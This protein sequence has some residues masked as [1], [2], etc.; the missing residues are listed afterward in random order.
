MGAGRTMGTFARPVPHVNRRG[1]ALSP[2]GVD[3]A[4]LSPGRAR[5]TDGSEHRLSRGF[6]GGAAGG[7]GGGLFLGGGRLRGG[8]GG[9]PCGPL[10][11]RL[12]ARRPGGRVIGAVEGGAL[13]AALERHAAGAPH[14]TGLLPT[15]LLSD[16]DRHLRVGDG[17]A[18]LGGAGRGHLLLLGSSSRACKAGHRTGGKSKKPPEVAAGRNK[19]VAGRD[20]A[21]AGRNKAVAGRDKAAARAIRPLQRAT[22]PLRRATRPSQG[23]PRPLRRDAG[24]LQRRAGG[25]RAAALG[26]GSDSGA[27]PPR[28]HPSALSAASITRPWSSSESA[29]NSGRSSERAE[30]RSAFGNGPAPA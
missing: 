28:R 1:C 16:V 17:Y 27:S 25:S 2:S 30:A 7:L 15:C 18:G 20:K 10:G 22:R 12:R 5:T 21:V 24:R 26:E 19:A 9:G 11:N 8:A 6:A 13:R 3:A 23:D 4:P 29:S 14:E